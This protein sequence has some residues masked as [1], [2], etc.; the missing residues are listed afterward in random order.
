MTDLV[1]KFNLLD[2]DSRKEILDFLDFLLTKKPK[3]SKK[4]ISEYKK[5]ILKVSV[6]SE[7]DID[8]VVE[9]QKKFDEWK[10]REW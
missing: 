10:A 6:W 7:G 9:N 5:K 3:A 2:K 8:V 4:K 1:F